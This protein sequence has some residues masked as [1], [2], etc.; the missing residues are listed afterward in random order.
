MN[1]MTF[2]ALLAALPLG[3]AATTAS[4]AHVDFFDAG[5]FDVTA[6]PGETR[7]HMQMV[8]PGASGALGGQ[9]ILE[10][11]NNSDPAFS[12]GDVRASLNPTG[13]GDNDDAAILEFGPGGSAS[14]SYGSFTDAFS[15]TF[16]VTVGD[17]NA[18]FFN[19]PDDMGNDTGFNW[20]GLVVNLDPFDGSAG[21]ANIAI[22]LSSGSGASGAVVSQ[23]VPITGPAGGSVVFSY[24]DFLALSPDLDLTDIDGVRFSITSEGSSS[25]QI[26]SLLRTGS[27]A[28]PDNGGG[29]NGTVIPSPAALPAGL[30][31]LAGLALRRRRDA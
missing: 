30:A 2:P 27:V 13:P 8:P 7:L 24:D 16:P 23:P 9:R 14:F 10:L 5:P 17:L 29:G 15:S 22:N 6:A 11:S 12:G 26:A 21:P 25:L 28:D 1:R 4:A 31:L 18:D 19:I 20:T 3:L